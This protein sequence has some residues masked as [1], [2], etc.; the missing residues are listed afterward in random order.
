ML[1]FLFLF[2]PIFF[3]ATMAANATHTE[4]SALE[5]G[6]A[7]PC[8]VALGRMLDESLRDTASQLDESTRIMME[9]LDEIHDLLGGIRDDLRKIRHLSKKMNTNLDAYN[10]TILATPIRRRLLIRRRSSR[11]SKS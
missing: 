7:S 4:A 6:S 5:N 1:L 11:T 9:K 8:E 3:I 2:L 10:R